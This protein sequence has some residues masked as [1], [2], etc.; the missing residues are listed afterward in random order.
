MI[1]KFIEQF[2]SE[3]DHKKIFQFMR[4]L[5]PQVIFHSHLSF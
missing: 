4:L 1:E 3:F 2:F 5:M